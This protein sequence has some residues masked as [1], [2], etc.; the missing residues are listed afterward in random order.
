VL[1]PKDQALS[2]AQDCLSESQKCHTLVV[3]LKT[4]K[5]TGDILKEMEA[6]VEVNK[7]CV[8][9]LQVLSCSHDIAVL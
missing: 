4:M 5:Y 2:C 3:Q 9:I 8:F 6:Y 1:Q 7:S